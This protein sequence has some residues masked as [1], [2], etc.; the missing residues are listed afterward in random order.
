[1]AS[2]SVNKVILIGHLGRDAETAYTASQVAVTKFSVAT[3]RRW[4][5]QQT[6]EWKE[7]TDWSRVVLWR[8]ENVAP[9]LTKGKQVYVEGRLQTRSYDDKDGKKVWTTEVVA[10]D[11][12]LL[13]GRGEGGM[14]GG[15]D[16]YSQEPAMRSAPRARP[17]AAPAAMPPPSEGV[18]EDDVPF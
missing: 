4:K 18:G 5:D 3:N 17:A 1:M 16:D 11:V 15:P 14:G 10:D 7:E 9:Y 13:G 12:I 8:G 2:R 6:G